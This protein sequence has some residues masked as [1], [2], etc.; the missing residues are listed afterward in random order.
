MI[1][2]GEVILGCYNEEKAFWYT[3]PLFS[4]EISIVKQSTVGNNF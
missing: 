4:E 3:N 2:K 1:F